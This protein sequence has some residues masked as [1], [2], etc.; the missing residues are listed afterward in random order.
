M[1]KVQALRLRP[2]RARL[3]AI[4]ESLVLVSQML[5]RDRKLKGWEWCFAEGVGPLR[6]QMGDPAT[7]FDPADFAPGVKRLVE[8]VRDGSRVL[9]A[10]TCRL[11]PCHECP[12]KL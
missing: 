8:R 1:S 9:L 2:A 10:E 3:P 11:C 12:L 7:I 4:T 5:E 6:R